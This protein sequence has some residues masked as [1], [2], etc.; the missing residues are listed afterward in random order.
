VANN[1]TIDKVVIDSHEYSREV[2]HSEVLL[3]WRPAWQI[4][5]NKAVLRTAVLGF[6]VTQD[7]YYPVV[8]KII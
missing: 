8:M 1:K 7:N 6:K 4:L 2:E 3:D 5:R